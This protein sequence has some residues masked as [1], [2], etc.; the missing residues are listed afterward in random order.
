MVDNKE[1]IDEV[2]EQSILSKVKNYFNLNKKLNIIQLNDFL[3]SIN[4][5]DVFSSQEEKDLIWSIF[6][7][8]SPEVKEIDYDTCY[9]GVIELFNFYGITGGEESNNRQERQAG[10]QNRVESS[11]QIFSPKVSNIQSPSNKLISNLRDSLQNKDRKLDELLTRISMRKNEAEKIP[12]FNT[13]FAEH[14]LDLNK[15]APSQF[16]TQNNILEQKGNRKGSYHMRSITKMFTAIDIEKLQQLR[17]VF[18]L[19]DL[20]NKDSVLISDIQ[21]VIRKY[22]FIKLT[23]DELINF[24]SLIS[25]DLNISEDKNYK[26]GIN[27]ELYS[28][29]IAVIE[30]Q[31]LQVNSDT[32]TEKNDSYE[33]KEN[34]S[35]IIDELNNVELESVDYIMVLA[36]I[37]KSLH[38]RMKESVIDNYEK[39]LKQ[40]FNG[41]E[42]KE[43][44]KEMIKESWNYVKSKVKDMEIFLTEMNVASS[45]KQNKLVYL[46]IAV[47][48]I[49]NDLKLAEE[50]YRYLFQKLNENNRNEVNEDIERL[51]DE[52]RILFE[53]KVLK[54]NQME[55]LEKKLGEKEEQIF[56]LQSK[57][58]QLNFTDRKE[59]SKFNLLKKD[60]DNLKQNYDTL[61]NEIYEKIK[62]EEE[63]ENEKMKNSKN[64]KNSK[65]NYKSLKN[66][67][68]DLKNT[69][70][71]KRENNSFTDLENF[72]YEEKNLNSN[73]NKFSDK[74]RLSEMEPEKLIFYT[75]DLENSNKRIEEIDKL[76]DKRI[77]DLESELNELRKVNNENAKTI[78]LLKLENDRLQKKIND[79]NRDIEINSIFRPSNVLASRLSRISIDRKSDL[80]PSLI[81]GD[82][83]N[84]FIKIQKAFESDNTITASNIY[85]TSSNNNFMIQP[86]NLFSKNPNSNPSSNNNASNLVVE[87]KIVEE[88]NKNRKTQSDYLKNENSGIE[89]SMT[90][91]NLLFSQKDSFIN[92]DKYFFD[93]KTETKIENSTLGDFYDNGEDRVNFSA[94]KEDKNYIISEDS[95]SNRFTLKDQQADF[96]N[97]N[98]ED[99][100]KEYIVDCIEEDNP[101]KK[102]TINKD[103]SVDLEGI[104]R[105][106]PLEID[107]DL[108]KREKLKLIA[109]DSITKSIKNTQVKKVNGKLPSLIT[110]EI[111][112]EDQNGE[113]IG[114]RIS[115]QTQRISSQRI[116][117]SN[118]RGS[119]MIRSI[120]ETDS[121]EKKLH[122]RQDTIEDIGLIFNKDSQYMCYDFLTLR[123]TEAIIKMFED[124][125]EDVSSYEMFSDNIYLV[126]ESYKKSKKNLFITSKVS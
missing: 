49:D 124:N 41:N 51:F 95:N 78:Y 59:E 29:A 14:D 88:D 86:S 43:S 55:N 123:K 48:R 18:S 92:N 101:F 4:L 105:N 31:L 97:E 61:L 115:S 9:R 103:D 38:I 110:E 66:K 3:D 119:N 60:Y 74:N 23:Q 85:N 40:N 21:E 83:A 47:N 65:N 33:V 15:N 114:Q 109:K 122:K 11:N 16:P 99:N 19:L 56:V 37:L 102:D 24:L 46:K 36:D 20:R 108:D 57:L 81:K 116:S 117:T 113:I 76:K 87:S 120:T 42:T 22:K 93:N 39:I 34:S 8:N 13:P 50:D 111:L 68:D 67:T 96:E 30:Q 75:L 2:I 5:A 73:S 84:R 54:E 71:I 104:V 98:E 82:Q 17:K 32:F 100:N 64:V 80:T 89:A 112:E 126:E 62:K 77:T 63:N 70:S 118:M 35:D 125:H 69:S 27:F 1:S 72:N 94:K 107:L 79:M 7:K 53:Q 6:T 44:L 52:N 10:L 12:H 45:K 58:D 28:R 91:T 25:D 106:S 26:M 121:D 90:N